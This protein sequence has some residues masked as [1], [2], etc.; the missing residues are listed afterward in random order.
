MKISDLRIQSKLALVL[1]LLLVPIVLLAWLF[2]Q[3]S[4]KDIDF[5]QKERDGLA[6]L[7]GGAWHVLIDLV[8]APL[9]ALP[10]KTI[11][12]SDIREL[13]KRYGAAMDTADAAQ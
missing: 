9:E 2:I 13:D 8:A 11:K 5:S 12:P 3:Q 1:T 10:A 6:Y 7:R 4:F